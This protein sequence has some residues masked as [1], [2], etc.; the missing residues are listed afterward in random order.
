M[1]V[2]LAIEPFAQGELDSG[3]LVEL[4][5]GLRAPLPGNW[6]FV[7]PV[8]RRSLEKVAAFEAWLVGEIKADPALTPLPESRSGAA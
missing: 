3:R 5:P 6:Y 4:F 7:T 2:A 1:G 8:T